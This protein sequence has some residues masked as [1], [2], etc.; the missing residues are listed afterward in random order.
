MSCENKDCCK[1]EVFCVDLRT[2]IAMAALNGIIVKASDFDPIR[3]SYMAVDY[4]DA[5]LKALE[6]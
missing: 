5:L 4:A 1:E 2:E 3:H 6:A